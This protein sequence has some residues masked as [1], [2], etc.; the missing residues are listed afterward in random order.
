MDNLSMYGA[1]LQERSKDCIVETEKGFATYRF[2]ND[3]KSV[4]IIDIYVVPAY[5]KE[6]VASALADTIMDIAR[7]WGCVEA[8]GTVVPSANNSTASLKVLLG[9]GMTLKSSSNDLIVFSKEI[10]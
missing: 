4:Y 6:K 1:Y 3:G 10:L 8:L 9:Y 2:I 5:R 7:E